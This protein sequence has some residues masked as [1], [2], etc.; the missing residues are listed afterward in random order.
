MSARIPIALALLLPA[1]E[2][3]PLDD[4][5]V[6]P[7]TLLLSSSL[8]GPELVREPEVGSGAG[9][10]VWTQPAEHFVATIHGQG[11]LLDAD[12][13]W[14]RY[15]V[16]DPDTRVPNLTLD[17]GTIELWLR[18]AF[19][20]LDGQD[21]HLFAALDEQGHGLRATKAGRELD[22]ALRVELVDTAGQTH[23]TVVASDV[24]PWLLLDWTL[25]RVAWDGSGNA[26]QNV[27]IWVDDVE[28]T[29]AETTDSIIDL[30]RLPDDAH[31]Y[32]GAWQIDD[33]QAIRGTLDEL[34][35]WSGVVLPEP[36]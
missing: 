34:H 29:Y 36:R 25:L 15:A 19:P 26:E 2:A 5:P 27:R 18:P 13:Q 32:L 7:G 30:P 6:D 3:E 24:L 8:D 35:V 16:R 17:A 4:P 11:V 21:R 23:A 1:C 10:A 22:N 12:G 33:D 20:V 9:A 31:L 14:L 28:L